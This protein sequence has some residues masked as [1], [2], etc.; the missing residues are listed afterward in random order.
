M[1]PVLRSF[2]E[3]A[4]GALGE[5]AFQDFISDLMLA[6]HGS[7]GF[8][9]MRPVRDRGC[10]GIILTEQCVLACYGPQKYAKG[11]FE[12]KANGDWKLYETHW[13]VSYPRWR[14]MVNHEVAPEQERIVRGLRKE[15]EI[16]GIKQI[17]SVLDNSVRWAKRRKLLE[18]SL[19]IPAE[20]IVFDV[21]H[22]LIEDLVESDLDAKTGP[23]E[24]KAVDLLAKIKT[25]YSAA[26]VDDALHLYSA[27]IESRELITATLRENDD[28]IEPFKLRVI[29]DFQRLA[30]SFPQRVNALLEL[31]EDKY[32]PGGDDLIRYH[33]TGI[34]HYVFE[35]CFIG[36]APPKEALQ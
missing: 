32:A 1:H 4:I 35:Q 36:Q 2:V 13:Q 8:Q 12:K 9:P 29:R 31:Y 28:W 14:M 10:D 19:N 24:Y 26:E 20:F 11:T 25:N 23:L 30:G 16:W 6:A 15:N 22:D 21:I 18:Q 33:L 27:T 3:R 34:I 7:S 17:V 5:N